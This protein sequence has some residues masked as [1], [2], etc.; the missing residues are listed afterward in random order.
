[1]FFER[2]YDV[3]L[4]QA[5]YLVGCEASGEAL[6]VDPNRDAEQYVRVAKAHGLR[7]THVTET[8]IHADFVSGTR[9]LARRTGAAVYLSGEGGADWQYRYAAEDGA[10]VLKN[11]DVI[12]V[13]AVRLEARHTPG[14]TPEHLSFVVTDT[15]T[16]D[17]PMGVFTG[18][19][20]FVGDVGRPDLLE[21]AARALQEFKRLPDYLQVWPGHGAGSACG[22]SLGAVPQTTVGY[23]LRFNWALGVAKEDDFVRQVLAG[24]P[25]P[26]KYF[27]EMKRVNRD[28]PR[29]LGDFAKPAR[30][31]PPRLREVLAAG[32][33]V[34]D[35]RSTA[36]Y[37]GGHVP[38]TLNIPLNN[39]F[40]TRAGWLV[41]YG[42]D[43]YL[44]VGDAEAERADA[45]AA[46]ARDLALIGFD[47]L[48]GYFDA[49][50]L[51]AWEAEG[52]LEKM[53]Q[54][55]AADVARR[56]DGPVADS[57]AIVDVRE[58]SEWEAGHIAG[59][60]NVPLG[61]LTDHVAELERGRPLVLHC[62]SG[63]RSS[64]AASLLRSLGFTNVFNLAEGFTGWQRR[65]LPVERPAP[66]EESAER[67]AARTEG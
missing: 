9:E 6:V 61:H 21:R 28:G 66:A 54:M 62:Q 38:R 23:E 36:D 1:M 63:G 56:L 52:S 19:F 65:G 46:A 22:K 40:T 4:A 51:A 60:L 50:A 47:R 58:R 20:V 31:D 10:R 43:V 26:P 27:G 8:H 64:V 55:G 48:A 5:S 53:P 35:T 24:Q 7:I 32:A 11:G 34:V 39:S 25:D 59:A 30:I 37:A 12:D 41:P 44:L 42:R 13:G 2:F 16:A 67:T 49:A 3:K 17:R 57:V 33:V 14:H 45:A 18:D 15:R 29:I